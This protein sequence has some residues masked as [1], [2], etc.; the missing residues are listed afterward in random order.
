NNKSGDRLLKMPGKLDRG[1]V[2]FETRIAHQEGE[3]MAIASRDVISVAPTT[4]IMG[5][6]KTMTECGFR[7]LPITDPGTRKLR[8]IVTAGDIIDMMGGGS[9]YNLV[10]V[11][12][13]GNFLPAINESV[14]EIMTEDVVT[15]PRTSRINDAV[16][17]IVQKKIGGIPIT[18]EGGVVNGIVTEK[19]VMKVLSLERRSVS[20]EEVM[21]TGLTVTT[22]D[23]PIGMATREMIQHRFRRLPVVSDDVLFGIITNSD[24]VRYLGSG[25]VF[26]KIVTGNIADVMSIPVRTLISGT[27]HTTTPGANINDA[28][29]KMLDKGVGA[30]PVIE[31]TRL[32]GL[33]TEY[34]MVTAFS[35]E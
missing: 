2:D 24:I 13:N 11:K 27:M 6:V 1:P 7:R 25:Q 26:Q 30:L 28:A 20:V 5:A 33:V 18:Y 29:R 17:I 16:K 35:K 3:I 31:D 14:R 32:V 8:G 12:H 34:D 19:D 15:L 4:T 22:P 10:Q 9:K 21:T 23:S